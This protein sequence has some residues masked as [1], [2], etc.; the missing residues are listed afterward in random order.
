MEKAVRRFL[1]AKGKGR[2][3]DANATGR[4]KRHRNQKNEGMRAVAE[5]GACDIDNST[6]VDVRRPD[7]RARPISP[8]VFLLD[9]PGLPS[10]L[11]IIK[12]ALDREEE[13]ELARKCLEEFST[14]DHTNLTN[15]R[16]LRRRQAEDR[17]ESVEAALADVP[18]STSLWRESIAKNDN[19]KSFQY[20]RW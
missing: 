11:Y 9:A 12:R 19:F 13:L 10:G 1:I 2:G 16:S 15:L 7:P 14:M 18:D 6:F 17:G 8:G 3:E 4:R 5:H 20:L